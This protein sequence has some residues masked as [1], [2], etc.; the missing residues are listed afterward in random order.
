MREALLYEKLPGSMVRC[1]TCQ[2]LCRIAPEKYG[3]CGM[4]QNLDGVL[5]NLNY[6]VVSSTAADPIEKKPLFH[7]FPGTLAFSVGTLGCNFHCR[8]CQN[9]EISMADSHALGACQELEPEEE[10]RVALAGGCQGIAWTYNEPAV[11]FEYTLDSA[12]LAKEKGL[13]TVYVTNG[14]STHDALDVIGPYLDAWRVDVKG[15]SDRFYR[16]L[17][18]VPRWRGILDTAERAR[19]RWNMHVEVVTNII[20]GMN[21]DDEQLRGIASWMVSALGEL[22]PWHVTRSYPRY[23]LQAPPTPL[24][25]LERACSIGREAGLRFVYTGNVPGHE[26]E[27]TVCYSCGRT[28]IRRV[29][30]DTRVLKLS[31]SKCG[32]CGAELNI[33]WAV[34]PVKGGSR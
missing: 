22:T 32:Y 21:D 1:H 6:A 11:W 28:V 26:A 29:G 16:D 12:R 17:A 13:Y 20:P 7:F 15:F 31:G 3:V 10:V 24:A 19:H 18:R 27:N 25:T 34:S 8:H 30:Y 23:R 4:Y 9:W 5:F 2:W 14:Y 33:R